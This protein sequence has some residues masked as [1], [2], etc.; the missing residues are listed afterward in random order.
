MTRLT[1]EDRDNLV[2]YLD[3]ELDEDTARDLE[4]KLNEDPLARAEAETLTQAWGLLDYL[5]RA[6]P[7][8]ALTHRTLER[9]ALQTAAMPRL[10]SSR[11]LR[12]L[13][14]AAAVLLAFGVGFATTHFIGRPAEDPPEV[15][16]H[17][18]RHLRAVDKVRAYEKVDDV[19]FLGE[20]DHPDLFGE[21]PGS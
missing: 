16:E 9:L 10:A 14:C 19:S 13:V 20:L 18:A 15:D 4:G 3:G 5:P 1:D 17:L 11:W 2:A 8:A 7:S 21:E 12:N 6:E